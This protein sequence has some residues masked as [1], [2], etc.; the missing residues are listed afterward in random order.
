MTTDTAAMPVAD[1]GAPVRPATSN[2]FRVGSVDLLRG[3]IIVIMALDHV[4]DF[5]GAL[6]ANPT[7]LAT[8]TVP[9]F[10]TRWITHFC[11]PVFFL[12][13]GTGASLALQ[14]LSKRELSRFLLT[15]GLWLLFLEVVV[16]R[17]AL[18]FNVD[19][20]VTIITVLWALGWAMIVLAG[21]IHLPGRAI[22]VFGVVLV[23]GHNLLDGIPASAFGHLAPL[24]SALHAPGF[25]VNTPRHLVFIA[26]PLIPWL[27]VTA[28]GYTLGQTYRW[29][30]RRRRALL[31]RLGLGLSVGFVLL[32]LLNVYGDPVAWSVQKS[33]LWTVLSF[34]DTNKYPPSLLF[35]LMTLGPALLLL[36]IFD[37]AS[38][39]WLRP[40]L[41]I[42][43]VPMFFYVLHFYL[44]HLLAVAACYIRFGHVGGMFRS[45]DLSH[46]PFTAPAGWAM[47]LPVIYLL[48]AAVVL[49]L[50]P[51]CRWYAGIKRRR[52]DW[53]L[54]YF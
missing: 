50:Y 14:R 23:A 41:T 6:G 2:R 17:F 8:T 51:L 16:M 40:A 33:P 36:R 34:L 49:A 27:G 47:S 29:S 15:R 24:W 4:H 22:V 32:R 31:L 48:W 25:L 3:I 30:G 20:Q 35:L 28:L 26:Y 13:A 45:P 9:L 52:K 19:Y 12:L 42:G 44:I 11:A 39:R 7:D 46:F 1:S 5:F 18:Q 53:W 10:L 43:K 21:L 38:P 54:S 37:S